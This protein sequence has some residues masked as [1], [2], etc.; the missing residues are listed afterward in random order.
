MRHFCAT[1][2]LL[3]G[4][5]ITQVRQT[6]RHQNINTTMTYVHAIERMKNTTEQIVADSLFA[7]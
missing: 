7:M 4:V 2:A 1:Q 6:L 5:N 3:N